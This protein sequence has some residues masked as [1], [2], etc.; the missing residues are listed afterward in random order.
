MLLSDELL[1]IGRSSNP[2][3]NMS[4][5]QA[6]IKMLDVCQKRLATVDTIKRIKNVLQLVCDT[7]NKE[8]WS[9][10]KVE[11][12]IEERQCKN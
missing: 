5:G 6:A 8:G 12:F 1:E 10:F 9:Y 7:L 4:M 3:S 11:L 2:K